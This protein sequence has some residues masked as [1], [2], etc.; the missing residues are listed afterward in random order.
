L[1]ATDQRHRAVFNGIWEVGKGFQVSGLHYLGAGIRSATTYGG[2]VRVTGGSFG[3]RL[4]PDGTVAPRNGFIQ[5]AQNRT[6]IRVQQRIPL[7]GRLSIDGIAEIFNVFNRPNF[8]IG[9]VESNTQNYLN[10]VSA[11]NRTAQ[12]GFRLTF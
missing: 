9:T 4:R 12:V 1:A 7:G 10:N 3:A 8:S 2:D 11:Q 5:P 6:D